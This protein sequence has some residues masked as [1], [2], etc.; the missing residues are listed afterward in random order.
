MFNKKYFCYY[1]SD[2]S[3]NFE[4]GKKM[5]YLKACPKCQGDIELISYPDNKFL[6]CLQC[7]FSIDSKEAAKKLAETKQ[8]A[9]SK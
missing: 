8:F 2:N 5:I 1:S 7:G 3:G 4:I 6:Q 9:H